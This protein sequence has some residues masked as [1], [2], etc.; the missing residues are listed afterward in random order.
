MTILL[1]A[2]VRVHA[3]RERLGDIRNNPSTVGP[4]GGLGFETLRRPRADRAPRC[5][6]FAADLI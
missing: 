2:I 6:M 4:P 3:L 5:F 1:T